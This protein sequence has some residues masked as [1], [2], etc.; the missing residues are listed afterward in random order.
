MLNGP[1]ARPSA[2]SPASSNV[3]TLH[4]DNVAT[5]SLAHIVATMWALE[6]CRNNAR[7]R[8]RSADHPPSAPHIRLHATYDSHHM[9]SEDK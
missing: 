7:A 1:A 3:A 5:M 8:T 6:H 9:S 4:E 2:L